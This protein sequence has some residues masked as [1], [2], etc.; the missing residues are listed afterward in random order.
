MKT[1]AFI[2]AAAA[3]A[4]FTLTTTR[5]AHALGP[6]DLEIAGK[7]GYGSQDLGFGFG[8]RAGVSIFGLYGGLNLVDY[9]GKSEGQFTPHSLEFG[10]EVGFGIKISFLTIRPQ[11]GFGDITASASGLPGASSFY[12]EPGGLLQFSFGHLIFGVDAGCLI[13]TTG[14]GASTGASEAFTIHGQVGV[15][16]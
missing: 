11:L 16:F 14:E 4:L 5:P 12:L 15:R 3:A 6:I 10:G 8:A 13:V 9:L 7:A 2:F 1:S